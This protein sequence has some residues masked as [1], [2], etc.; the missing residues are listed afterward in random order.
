MEHLLSRDEIHKLQDDIVRHHQ[1]ARYYRSLSAH[2][3]EQAVE[4][5]HIAACHE[6]HVNQLNARL[7]RDSL[8][9]RNIREARRIK[10]FNEKYSVELQYG[11]YGF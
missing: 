2:T 7:S 10:L 3:T 9:K 11:G 6:L 1:A 4:F 5:N 8:Q